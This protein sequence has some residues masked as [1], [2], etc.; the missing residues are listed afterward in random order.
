[1]KKPLESKEE[2]RSNLF[3]RR[4]VTVLKFQKTRK[5]QHNTSNP[6]TPPSAST[7]SLHLA[8]HRWMYKKNL[9]VCTDVY[10][11]VFMNEMNGKGKAND[12]EECENDGRREKSTM[13]V[14]FALG[15]GNFLSCPLLSCRTDR[16]H[17]SRSWH[18][19]APISN[20]CRT[21][22]SRRPF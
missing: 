3:S 2:F 6:R 8:F 16:N 15:I 12:S 21:W 19:E 20:V 1:M 5:T 17:R 11:S 9:G 13:C 18:F 10:V 4:Y 7:K 22:S 14:T